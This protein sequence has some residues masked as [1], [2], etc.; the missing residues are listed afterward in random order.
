M[1][2]EIHQRITSERDRMEKHYLVGRDNEVLFYQEQILG[3][4]F[5]VRILNLYGTG[6]VGKSYLLN[7]FRRLS[8]QAD[9]KFLILDSHVFPRNPS[10][11]CLYLL[12]MLHYPVQSIEPAADISLLNDECL[13]ALQEAVGQ[14]KMVLAL[15]TFEVI[16]EMESW[17]RDVFLP[18]LKSNILIIISGRHPLQ[19]LWLSSPVWRQFIY[20]MPLAGF[21]YLSVK[22]FLELSNIEQEERIRHVYA[23]S[24]GHPLTLALL[25]ANPSALP[26]QNIPFEDSSETFRYVVNSWLTEV[27]S[28]DMRVLV[29]TAAVVRHFNQELLSYVMEKEV[30]TEQFQQLL[31]LSFV[32]RVDRGWVLH[33]LLR[34]AITYELRL[35]M[36]EY[37]NRL[38][39]RCVLYYYD[40]IKQTAH[41]KIMSWENAEWFYYIGNQLIQAVFYQQSVC[42]SSEP[43]NPSNRAE[44][45]R[46]IVNRHLNA[47]D[48]RI[49]LTNP[50]TKEEHDYLIT[51]EDSLYGLK[52]IH[53]KEL[54]ELD[55]NSVKLTRDSQGTV[56]GL[57]V[58]IP[59]NVHTL[60]YLRSKPLSSVYFNS[61]P[62]SKL[63]ELRVPKH[64]SAGYF[65]KTLDIYDLSDIPMLQSTGLTFIT[66]MLACGYVVAAPPPIPFTYAILKSLGCEMTK[67]VVHFD[68]D[69]KI[70][71]P[72]FVIDTRGNKLEHY[73]NR[74]VASFGIL[75][76]RKGRDEKNASLTLKENAVIE[77]VIK[78]Y[79]NL[80]IAKCLFLSESTVK[81]HVSNIYRKLDVNKR[82][83]LINKY[84]MKSNDQ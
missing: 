61:L 30:T 64:S 50:D 62:E 1:S 60:D 4:T 58:I 9:I 67:D 3:D 51:S 47:K 71:S 14:K 83:Q 63:K 39:K 6:G 49:K 5:T 29:E 18:N 26:L 23:L 37:Y 76:E 77:L 57:S 36:P 24:K 46:Y 8:E 35:R 40:K 10:E 34:D 11:F 54:Y 45:E 69:E 19:G 42:Y 33:D 78:G 22:R 15:D 75:E 32:Q 43:L 13:N 70:P 41:T 28:P 73:L 31:K 84:P 81:K 48:V 79:S 66:H 27:H 55:P 68:Y 7:E 20:R 80:E 72:L 25:V 2:R 53:L 82:A 65:F 12:H 38:W 44:A 21:D 17:L 52:H 74:M 56:C 16:G 59:I